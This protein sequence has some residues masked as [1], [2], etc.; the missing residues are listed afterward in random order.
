VNVLTKRCSGILT[1]VRNM[2]SAH[3]PPASKSAD[4]GVRPQEL[5]SM[6]PYTRFSVS[7]NG[8]KIRVFLFVS[9]V[10]TSCVVYA[11]RARYIRALN[12]IELYSEVL[13]KYRSDTGTYPDEAIGLAAL[14]SDYSLVEGKNNP[15]YIRKISK[16]PWGYDYKYR[17]PGKYNSDSFDLWSNGANGKI[18]GFG[19]DA[20]CG[21]WEESRKLCEQG[22]HVRSDLSETL[23]YAGFF[24][25]LGAIVG[26]PLYIAGV[27]LRRKST[28]R[29]FTG[30]HLAVFVYL[31]LIGPAVVAFMKLISN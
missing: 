21:N 17:H 24:A 31:T 27:I 15:G 7:R 28:E 10:L 6:I 20:D 11:E 19:F 1:R 5:L 8:K 13:E 26:L 18:G 4:L 25:A 14:L 3:N 23:K 2:G 22:H 16:D 29:T 9:L 12:D 30:F